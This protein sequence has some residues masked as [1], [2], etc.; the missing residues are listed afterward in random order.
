VDED[1]N[2]SL[3]FGAGTKPTRGRGF[4]GGFSRGTAFIALWNPG[5][6]AN[7]R[8]ARVGN[9]AI[10]DRAETKNE[11]QAL[12]AMNN[13]FPAVIFL[14]AGGNVGV[15]AVGQSDSLAVLELRLAAAG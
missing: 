1:K 10:C 4:K 13:L 8:L 6:A 9:H 7:V 2:R 3:F 15:L 14:F 11:M 5:A 12:N